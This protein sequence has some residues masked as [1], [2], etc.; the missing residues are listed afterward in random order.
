M[1]EIVLIAL[2]ELAIFAAKTVIVTAA[3]AAGIWY[4]FWKQH[5]PVDPAGRIRIP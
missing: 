3:V 2:F 4:F 5:Q 1:I